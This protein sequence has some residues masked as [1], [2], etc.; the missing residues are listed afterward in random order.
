MEH[1]TRTLWLSDLQSAMLRGH[2]YKLRRYTT[3]NE[4]FGVLPDETFGSGQY[5][6]LNYLAIGRGA[7][8]QDVGAD[9][10]YYPAIHQHRSTDAALFDHM[11]FA[12]RR[13]DDDLP[14]ERRNHFALRTQTSYHGV[15]YWAYWL[16]RSDYSQAEVDLLL[17]QKVDENTVNVTEYQ[18]SE[19]NLNPIPEDM[20]ESGTNLLAGYSVQASSILDVAL[21]DFAINEIRNA[22]KIITQRADRAIVSELALC[23]GRSKVINAP[24]QNGVF[25]FQEAVGVQ[26]SA[27]IKGMYALD[28][29]NRSLRDQLELGISE[30]LFQMEGHN[31]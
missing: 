27:F 21:D 4:K 22:S 11:P 13:L 14:P 6:I 18:P 5:P 10:K 3:L 24:T 25:S 26:V 2:P 9:G 30:P 8:M 23:T 16:M 1:V 7:L 19:K 15:A 31:A 28:F 20:S 17:K 29:L 12:L